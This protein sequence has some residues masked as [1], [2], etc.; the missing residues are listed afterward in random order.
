MEL[1]NIVSFVLIGLVVA[2]AAVIIG[3][4]IPAP[5]HKLAGDSSEIVQKVSLLGDFSPILKRFLFDPSDSRVLAPAMVAA[6]GRGRISSRFP[7]LGRIWL[8]LSWNLY[9]VPGSIFVIHN[10]ITWFGRNF[11]RGGEEYRSG[12]G[13]FLL[14]KKPVD[15]PYLDE[16]ERALVWLYS[17]WLAPGSLVNHPNVKWESDEDKVRI[18]VQEENLAPLE[19]SLILESE[20]GKLNKIITTRKGSRTGGDY[21]FEATL[22]EPKNFGE[23]GEIPTRWIAN[24]DNDVYLKLDLA[25]ISLKVDI[26]PVMQGGIEALPA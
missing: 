5:I 26:N 18:C 8:P 13:E 9:L 7:I 20:T 23:S 10:R 6:W 15:N 25:G 12:K 19:F 22:L 16:T 14:G 17:I 2:I 24:W 1:G 3:F 11:I 21:P 4:L